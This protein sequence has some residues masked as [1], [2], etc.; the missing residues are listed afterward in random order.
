MSFFSDIRNYIDARVK[1]VDANLEPD[2]LQVFGDD[3]VGKHLADKRYNLIFKELED[4]RDDYS[5]FESLACQLD[6]YVR[7]RQKT[8]EAFD[9]LYIK[10]R[11]IRDEIIKKGNYPKDAGKN[12]IFHDIQSESITP[13]PELDND[14]A[15]RM[16]LEFKVTRKYS[17]D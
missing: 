11:C 2:K 6:I 4:D 10:A 5:Y 16:R 8:Q 15:F 1:A 12:Y 13:T 17:L 7:P 3:N 9:D 14:K